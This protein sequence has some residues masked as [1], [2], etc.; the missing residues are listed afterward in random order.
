MPTTT[1]PECLDD[2]ARPASTA[3]PIGADLD[4]PLPLDLLEWP[5]E[6]LWLYPHR[7]AFAGHRNRVEDE[8][9]ARV[10]ALPRALKAGPLGCATPRN[11]EDFVAEGQ[12][13]RAWRL[14]ARLVLAAGEKGIGG[15]AGKI[16]KDLAVSALLLAG[17]VHGCALGALEAAAVMGDVAE[18]AAAGA[19]DYPGLGLPPH[20]LAA[21]IYRRRRAVLDQVA[22]R[23]TVDG[24]SP[25]SVEALMWR[26][27]VAASPCDTDEIGGG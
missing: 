25:R 27:P 1:L 23:V 6:Q 24:G 21:R 14:A 3:Q 26:A 16:A 7:C 22:A 12:P 5:V 10:A 8:L 9:R 11:V 18:R 2:L 4:P 13:D 19:A 15:I 17:D 20:E